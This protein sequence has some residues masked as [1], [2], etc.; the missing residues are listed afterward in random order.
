MDIRVIHTLDPV[1]MALLRRVAEGL[2]HFPSTK[3]LHDMRASLAAA[4]LAS[5]SLAASEKTLEGSIKAY[6]SG[7]PDRIAAAVAAALASASVDDDTAAGLIEAASAE[8]A[9]SVADSLIA[10][11]TP[12]PG[13][14]TVAGQ[15]APIDT[16]NGGQ[17]DDV[18]SPDPNAQ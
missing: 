12:G 10:I 3:E 8:A 5:Q 14:D 6:V 11:T 7:E 2:H 16:V 13:T 1:A 15:T 4:I 17:G 9:T 18:V